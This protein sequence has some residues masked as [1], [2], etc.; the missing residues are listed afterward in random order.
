MNPSEEE[1]NIE[2]INVSD[3]EGET[4]SDV[5]T[6]TDIESNSDE[7]ESVASTDIES[8]VE[9]Q[10]KSQE[11]TQE[12]SEEGGIFS[13]IMSN[14]NKAT[15]G[16]F[17]GVEGEGEEITTKKTVQPIIQQG[18]VEELMEEEISEDSDDESDN[19]NYLK[20]FDREIREN[21]IVDTHPECVTHN[22][23]EVYNLAKVVRDSNNIIID[24]LHK[25][26]PIMTKYEKTRILGQRAKQINDGAKPFIKIN[27]NVIDGYLIAL[28]E[29]EEKKLPFIIRRPLPNGSSEYWHV[30]DLEVIY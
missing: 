4:E 26:T 12:E 23:D 6:T 25:T 10:D 27:K 9:E 18:S 1:K 14:I 16:L 8:E 28:K 15:G 5:E 20:K 2:E 19:E 29:L 13:N 21:Y 11:E 30:E 7:T 3:S 22:Y 24:D 17:G